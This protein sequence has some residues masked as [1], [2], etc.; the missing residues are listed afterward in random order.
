MPDERMSSGS[1]TYEDLLYEVADGVATVTINRPQR[2]NAMRGQTLEELTDALNVAAR[3]DAVGV[4]V[5]TGAGGHF[6]GGG[7][8]NMVPGPDGSVNI[9]PP[10]V[11]VALH[12]LQAFRLC[13]KPVIGRVQGSCIGMG[14]ELNLL[15]DLTIAGESARFG[16]AGPRVGSVPAAG[17]TQLLSI[18]CGLKRAKEIMFLCRTYSGAAAVEMGLANVVVPDD[19]LDDEVRRWCDELLALSPQSL[20]IAK[21]SLS[22]VLDQQW[23]SVL[24]GAELA[25][26]F[27]R[28]GDIVE[29][30]AAFL[31]KRPADFRAAAAG[32]SKEE[33]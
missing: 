24:H 14:N 1:P 16:Q 18:V 12:W 32:A 22:T 31:E 19:E 21:L 7:D 10:P 30:A 25:R 20:R 3:D 11:E 26:W 9:E 5:V 4:V 17:G 13:P 28:S 15:C 27:T 2:R 8:L 6:C 23:S 29:G 33:S